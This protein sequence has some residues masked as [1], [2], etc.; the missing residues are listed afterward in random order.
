M[1]KQLIASIAILSFIILIAGCTGLQTAPATP[2]PNPSHTMVLPSPTP[3]IKPTPAPSPSGKPSTTTTSGII[4]GTVLYN[5]FDLRNFEYEATI[6]DNA[7]TRPYKWMDSNITLETY[8]GTKAYHWTVKDYGNIHNL[9]E[10]I[11]YYY[12]MDQNLIG[13]Y[14]KKEQAASTEF[15]PGTGVY[16]EANAPRNYDYRFDGKETITVHGYQYQDAARYVAQKTPYDSVTIW[17]DS[18]IS[19]PIKIEYVYSNVRIT[20]ELTGFS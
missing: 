18:Y 11:D 5:P 10:E 20:Y 3:T 14:W 2:T 15:S 9:D 1:Y 12:N 7:A 6:T 8:N 19:I 16:V 17:A 4:S 13:G